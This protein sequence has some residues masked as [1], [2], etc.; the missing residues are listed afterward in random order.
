MD[1]I[2]LSSLIFSISFSSFIFLKQDIKTL[3]TN[4]YSVFLFI[5]LCQADKFGELF[6]EE[7]VDSAYRAVAVLGDDKLGDIF[8]FGFRV[9]VIFA[10]QEHY[11][12]GVLFE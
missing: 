2:R 12:I 11:N 9:V 5:H 8:V 7:Q 1:I 10:V 3:Y 6:V 4:A